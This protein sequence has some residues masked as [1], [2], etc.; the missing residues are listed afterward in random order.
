VISYSVESS[1]VVPTVSTT[2]EEDHA[3]SDESSEDDQLPNDEDEDEMLRMTD[4]LAKII[5]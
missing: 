4:T 2:R 1:F 5:V 3:H